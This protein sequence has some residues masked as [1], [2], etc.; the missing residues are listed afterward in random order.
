MLTAVGGLWA[1]YNPTAAWAKFWFLVASFFLFYMLANQPA[2]RL[3]PVA[4]LLGLLGVFIGVYFLL[5][6][7]WQAD[8]TYIGFLDSLAAKWTDVR[9]SIHLSSLGANQIAG[10]MGMLFPFGIASMVHGWRDWPIGLRVG[11][12]ALVGLVVLALMLTG[13]RGAFLALAIALSL[14]LWSAISYRLAKYGNRK[15]PVL[16]W[17]GFGLAFLIGIIGLSIIPGNLVTAANLLPGAASADSRAVI[18]SNTLSLL[19]DFPFIGGGLDSFAGLYS[20][21]VLVI[22]QRIFTYAHNLYLDVALEQGILGLVAFLSVVIGSFWLLGRP[23]TQVKLPESVNLLR[24]AVITGLVFMLVR[25]FFDDAFFG[26]RGT[27]LLFLL[28]GFAVAL[29]RGN[30]WQDFRI[31]SRPW[32]IAGLL[33]LVVIVGNFLRP[34]WRAAWAANLG[35]IQMARVELAGWP[36]N[37][38]D[39]GHTLPELQPAKQLFNQALE[40]DPTNRTA[41][42]RLGMISMLERDY[43]TAVDYLEAAQRIDDEHLGIRK[44]LAYS[45]LWANQLEN[46]RP[47]LVTIPEAQN[48]LMVYVWWWGIQGRDDL[49]SQAESMLI[50][51]KQA[52]TISQD[53][54]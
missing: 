19:G 45:Y 42:H 27:P 14:W 52:N 34:Q 9:P 23:S 28:P 4:Q 3:W 40:I 37:K 43:E 1:A 32:G 25:G 44:T 22:P 26:N 29:S 5:T 8:P 12:L 21:Y 30:V 16:F 7:D 11:F 2:D 51:L 31:A 35:A 15:Q 36:T 38:W 13:S 6:Q 33:L 24:W 18:Y 54:N 17:I 47:L 39:D 46:A 10:L 53:I 49:V 50:L 41:N 20:Q 48:E